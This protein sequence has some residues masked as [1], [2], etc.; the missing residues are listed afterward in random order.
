M[1]RTT[2]AL[3]D[4]ALVRIIEAFFVAKVPLAMRH[5]FGRSAEEVALADDGTEH[6]RCMQLASYS[7]RPGKMPRAPCYPKQL[8]RNI[9]HIPVAGCLTSS[10][11][12]YLSQSF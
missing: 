4:R 5:Q 11:T 1:R 3:R 10:S 6:G 8:Q 7:R 9:P 2:R 12:L